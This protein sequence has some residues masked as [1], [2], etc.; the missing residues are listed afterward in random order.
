M[1]PRRNNIREA[2][3][4]STEQDKLFGEIPIFTVRYFTPSCQHSMEL[5]CDNCG[6]GTQ[7]GFIVSYVTPGIDDEFETCDVTLCPT[8]FTFGVEPKL[9]KVVGIVDNMKDD[10]CPEEKEKED[11]YG[12]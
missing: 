3:P 11:R 5:P 12:L 8:C 6:C 9:H 2:S 7:Q 10:G 4:E 1:R